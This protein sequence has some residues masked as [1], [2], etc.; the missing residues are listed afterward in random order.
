[1]RRMTAA[2]CAPI[3]GSGCRPSNHLR[4]SFDH[5]CTLL[6]DDL[7]LVPCSSLSADRL[8]I[9]CGSCVPEVHWLR[10]D[11]AADR[12]EWSGGGVETSGRCISTNPISN[13]DS[14]RVTCASALSACLFVSMARSRLCHFCCGSTMSRIVGWILFMSPCLQH[15]QMIRVGGGYVQA[16]LRNRQREFLHPLLHPV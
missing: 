15:C 16:S 1:M 12:P 10:Q 14:E 8:I 9:V 5:V 11:S 3:N 13:D 2:I 7:P 4:D 6:G